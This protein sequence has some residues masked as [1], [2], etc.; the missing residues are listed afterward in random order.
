MRVSITIDTEDEETAVRLLGALK[1]VGLV[2]AAEAAVDEADVRILPDTR[3]VLLRDEP[4]EL[5][6]LE[7][8]L[9]LHLCAHPD[10]VHR[11][12]ELLAAVWGVNDNYSG[13]RTV[14]VHVRRVRQ[15]LGDAADV[16]QTVRGVGYLVASTGRVRVDRS[17][18]V[19]RLADRRAG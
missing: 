13:A 11:R 8:E 9:L 17:P 10:R 6:R 4:V 18:N 1:D 2:H 7:F 14:D 3:Q 5:T 16:I 12:R 15:K 19:V